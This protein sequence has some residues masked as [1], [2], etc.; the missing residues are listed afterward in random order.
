M[1]L[2]ARELRRQGRSS[3]ATTSQMDETFAVRAFAHQRS[4]T[5]VAWLPQMLPSGVD[6]DALSIP[7]QGS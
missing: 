1:S 2:N 7:Q 4:S 6:P 5:G 3:H